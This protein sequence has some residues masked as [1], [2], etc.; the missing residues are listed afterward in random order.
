MVYI[1]IL[2]YPGDRTKVNLGAS[3][4]VPFSGLTPSITNLL[5]KVAEQ[6]NS[7]SCTR[8]PPLAT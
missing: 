6:K 4:K 8:I 1:L 5:T 7:L 2:L 3:L